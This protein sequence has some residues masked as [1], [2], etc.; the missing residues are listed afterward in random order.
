MEAAP[1]SCLSSNAPA[2]VSTLD[3]APVSRVSVSVSALGHVLDELTERRTGLVSKA[4]VYAAL[5]AARPTS[6]RPDTGQ[7]VTAFPKKGK[8]SRPNSALQ[9]TD[10]HQF[11]SHASS[12][13]RARQRQRSMPSLVR[14]A[15]A[16]H[17][18]ERAAGE[19]Q[20][21]VQALHDELR[22]LQSD[23]PEEMDSNLLL[24]NV[25][26][27]MRKVAT[28]S[29]S[30]HNLGKCAKQRPQSRERTAAKTRLHKQKSDLSVAHHTTNALPTEN[31]EKV[32]KGPTPSLLCF[33]RPYTGMRSTTC[34]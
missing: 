3:V 19:A 33:S 23:E 21:A 30:A 27:P 11:N 2:A 28:R 9:K 34:W 17:A 22:L 8:M 16:K 20:E 10:C 6:S 31:V 12:A 7:D 13:A 5:T 32:H 4:D 15:K 18:L 14:G 26:T 29:A 25:P 24:A 1:G